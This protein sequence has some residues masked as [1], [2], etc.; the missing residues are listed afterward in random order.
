MHIITKEFSF[1]A[2]HALRHLPAGHKCKNNH[3]HSY[4]VRVVLA[5]DVLDENGFV[6]DFGDLDV[7]KSYI[8]QRL[9]H[10]YLN[11]VFGDPR[12]TTSENLAQHFFH[13]C[14]SLGLP[15]IAAGVSETAKTWAWYSLSQTFALLAHQ[16]AN[17]GDS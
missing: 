7:V 15:V 13:K 3:G 17:H 8:D 16:G 6:V 11:D 1:E 9:D 14:F 10:H 2:S 12:L 5:S 4:R